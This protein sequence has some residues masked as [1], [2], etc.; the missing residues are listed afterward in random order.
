MKSPLVLGTCLSAA[1]T[2]TLAA[3]ANPPG[4]ARIVTGYGKLPL[5]FEANQGQSDPQ[6]KYLSRGAGYSLLLTSNEALLALKPSDPSPAG[7]GQ[8]KNGHQ[9]PVRHQPSAGT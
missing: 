5:A 4:S 3:Q 9:P 7:S 8:A 2:L 6:V 1:L